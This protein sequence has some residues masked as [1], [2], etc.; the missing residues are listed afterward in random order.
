M[1]IPN[2]TPEGIAYLLMDKILIAEGSR[3]SEAEARKTILDLYGQCLRV[4]KDPFSNRG[5]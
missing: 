3:Y 2:A 1:E 4:T 5:E